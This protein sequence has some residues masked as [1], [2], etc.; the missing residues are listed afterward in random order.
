MNFIVARL[1]SYILNENSV[2]TIFLVWL[3]LLLANVL[4]VLLTFQALRLGAEEANPVMRRW[5]EIDDTNTF[6]LSFKFLYVFLLG[7]AISYRQ[8][9]LRGVRTGFFNLSLILVTLLQ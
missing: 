1:L 9:R 4:D 5:F 3:F 6:V 7:V 8:I 2:R